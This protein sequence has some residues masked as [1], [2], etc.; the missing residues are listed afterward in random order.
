[1]IARRWTESRVGTLA[2][3]VAFPAALAL[4]WQAAAATGVIDPTIWASP[5][6]VAKAVASQARDA[7]FWTDMGASL[8]RDAQGTALG[9]L[10]GLSAG[11]ALGRSR[12]V[13]D[14]CGPTLDAAKAVPVF[15]WVPLLSVWFGSGEAGKIIFIALVTA[16]PVLFNTAEGVLSLEPRHLELIR[17]YHIGRVARFRR[18]ILPGAGPA[19]LR[20]VHQ[21]VL[22]GWLATIGAEFL[23]EAGNGIGT[24]INGEKEL[25][26]LDFVVADML[27]IG[28]V[29]IAFDLG[30][31]R[32][33]KFLLRWRE[34]FAA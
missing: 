12:L 5:W 29:G 22:F 23:F 25:Y 33:E 10:L 31:G 16:L 6:L 32:I 11:L 2:L 19:I 27:A 15:T 34:D 20:G 18:V 8:W 17:L 24:N 14:F 26:A 30:F 28:L 3:G 4:V 1:M 21:A 7:Q 9:I 13:R